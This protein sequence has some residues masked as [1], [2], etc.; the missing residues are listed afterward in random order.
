MV[1]V[2]RTEPRREVA[3][4]LRRAWALRQLAQII[5]NDSRRILARSEEL[6]ARARRGLLR[7]TGG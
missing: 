3:R 2:V 5:A 1:R 4:Q 6:V 7:V